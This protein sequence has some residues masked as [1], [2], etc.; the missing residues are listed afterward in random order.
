MPAASLRKSCT[1]RVRESGV[2]LALSTFDGPGSVTSDH[3]YRSACGRLGR[4]GLQGFACGI[5]D[6]RASSLQKRLGKGD[7]PQGLKSGVEWVLTA[8]LRPPL[9]QRLSNQYGVASF[10]VQLELAGI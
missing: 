10:R 4:T 8:W 3:R 1:V 7:V 2:T 9:I 6:K 5:M